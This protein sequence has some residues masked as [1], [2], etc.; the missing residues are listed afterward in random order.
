MLTQEENELMTRVGPGKPAGEMLRRYWWPVAFTDQVQAKA[1]P[2]KVTLLA[3]R[4]CAVSRRR[5]QVGI[6]GVALFPSRHVV[7]VR[8]GRRATAFAAAIMAGCGTR[9]AIA[10][11]NRRSR[12]TALSKS[13]SS[14]RLFM[15]RMPAA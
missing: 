7:G 4:L 6:G 2:T 14:I 13:G 3:R 12:P 5:R 10:W 15:R 9:A 8:P 11:T 1:A